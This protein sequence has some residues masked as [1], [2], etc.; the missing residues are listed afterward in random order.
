[1]LRPRPARWWAAAAPVLMA[2]AAAPQEGYRLTPEEVVVD[3]TS[4][5]S[6][7]QLPEGALELGA[8]GTVTPRGLERR[9]NA[10]LNAHDYMAILAA[11]DTVRGG[12][13][14]VGS[15]A[16]TG[17]LL[18]DGDPL[19]WWEPDPADDAE[20]WFIE[21]DLG[22]AVIAEQVVVRFAP[23]GEGDPFLKFRVRL[24][25]GLGRLH[26]DMEYFRAGQVVLPNKDGRHFVFDIK[27][28]RPLPPGV[29]G[30]VAQFVRLEALG[31]DGDRGREVSPGEFA[32]LDPEERG[33]VDHYR[34]T[35][36]GREILVQE[37]TWEALP[38]AERGPVRRYRRERPRVAELEVITPGE[39]VVLNT[40]RI[41]NL[42][43]RAIS[44]IIR[45]YSTDGFFYSYYPLKPYDQVRRRNQLEVDLGAKYWLDRVRMITPEEPLRAYQVM[46]SDGSIDPNGERVWNELDER[47][48]RERFLQL[49][50]R[51][52]L[53]EVR[54]V[55]LRALALLGTEQES[56]QLA[57]LLAFGEGFVSEVILTSPLITLPGSRMFTFL[58]WEG[59]APRETRI[60]IRTRSG[61]DLRQE[62]LYYDVVGYP[63]TRE[64]WERAREHNRGRV[65]TV[66]VPG[67]RWSSWSEVYRRSPE[68]FRSPSPRRYAMAEVRLLTVNPLRRAAI[69]SLRIGMAE[70]LVDQVWAE[71]EPS[72]GVPPGVDQEFTI[73]MRPRFRAGDPG[74]DR[75]GIRSSSSA[76]VELLSLRAG[77]EARLRDGTA[78]DLLAS[79]STTPVEGGVDVR[80][81]GPVASGRSIY[82]ARIRTQ[83]YLSGTTFRIELSLSAQ[84]GTLQIASEGDATTLAQSQSLVV[85]SDLEAGRLLAPLEVAPPVLTPN[86]DGVNDEAAIS[87]QV[88]QVRGP[89]RLSVRVHD[90]SGRLVRDLTRAPPQASGRHEFRWDG[91]DDSGALVAPGVYA[92]RVEVGVHAGGRRTSRVRLVHVAY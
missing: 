23:E 56:G 33:A 83:V 65:D 81:P 58:S 52:P 59:E 30:Q 49:E 14:E 62:L 89:P 74:F 85:I 31:S 6:A 4:H 32:A 21:I 22:R 25:N 7:W 5:W 46:L 57:E 39:N 53:Q 82:A 88:F 11:S 91:R 78:D 70:P 16:A 15:G 67:P 38:E 36:A 27:A 37:A 45:T 34:R 18:R 2:A 55:Q 92:A 68:P 80:F 87:F 66:Y 69:R 64:G 20:D 1:M 9:A 13:H 77:T 75:L 26:D 43:T 63:M 24:S 48:N 19:T 8:D 61:D 84:P 51:F 72:S 47:L 44:D 76:P 50:E 35:V 73:Y 40:Q 54:H 60:E 17:D 41:I 28:Q 29:T 71:I 12:I 79:A 90:L 42:R 10:A 3:R 86:G